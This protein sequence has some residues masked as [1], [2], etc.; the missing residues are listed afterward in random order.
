[1]GNMVRSFWLQDEGELEGVEVR[2]ADQVFAMSSPGDQ[3]TRELC[4]ISIRNWNYQS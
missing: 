4:E 3:F 1:M 2:M